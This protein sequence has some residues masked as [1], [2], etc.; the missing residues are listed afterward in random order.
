M[1]GAGAALRHMLMGRARM[2]LM[3]A[4]VRARAGEA[5]VVTK[6]SVTPPPPR[7]EAGT[8]GSGKASVLGAPVPAWA[9]RSLP[10][11]ALPSRRVSR[12]VSSPAKAPRER[13][14]M[15][16]AGE[17]RAMAQDPGVA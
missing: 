8:A 6:R 3:R 16:E 12:A 11:G 2:A 9:L 4:P 7:A 15:V 13:A 10:L 17:A 5:A 1:G 14:G